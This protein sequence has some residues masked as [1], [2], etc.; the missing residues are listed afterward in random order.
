MFLITGANGQLGTALHALL[1]DKAEYIDREDLDLTNEEAVKTFFSNKHYDFVINC[2]AYT[3][4]DK[5]EEDVDTAYKINALAPRYLGKY[6][7]NVIH[8]STDYVFDG[9]AYTPYTE[10]ITPTP[11]SVYGQTKREGEIN[12]IEQAD[13]AIVIRTS[14]LYSP[15]GT[16][17]VKTIR[18][19]ASERESLNV[20]FD[21]IGTPTNAYDLAQAIIS[22]I[23]QIAPKEKGIYHFSNEGVCSWYDFATEIVL[24]SNL[25]CQINPIESKDYKTLAKR[26]FYSVL[27]KGKIK[28]RFNITIPHWKEGLKQ[29]LKLF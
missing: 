20:I 23:P 2:A 11:L 27:N 14:W 9:M 8:I 12:V 10:D 6:A 21:Q 15:H 26:P 7:K 19:L 25:T 4:V 22:I 17:F 28:Q 13:T 29:C 1:Q 16:N 18:K 24:Q 3:A 5:A